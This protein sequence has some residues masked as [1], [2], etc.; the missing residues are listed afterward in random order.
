MPSFALLIIFFSPSNSSLLSHPSPSIPLHPIN[1]FRQVAFFPL[2][3]FSADSHYLN[4][5][6]TVYSHLQPLACRTFLLSCSILALNTKHRYSQSQPLPSP[7]PHLTAPHQTF[8]SGLLFSQA[9][10]LSGHRS[11][12][13]TLT[14]PQLC[15][16]IFSVTAC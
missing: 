5:S 13:L 14:F 9:Q 3:K 12:P 8:S 11:L 2:N 10:H 4:Q 7:Q 15:R 1:W 6:R 16:M